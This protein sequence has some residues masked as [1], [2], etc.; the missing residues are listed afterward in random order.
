MAGPIDMGMAAVL[1]AVQ[2]ATEFLPVSSS[3]HVALGA[4]LFGVDDM[5]LAMVVL[6]HVGTLVATLA[7]FREDLVEL[8]VAT[9]RGVTRPR[10]FL[11]TDQGKLVTG[12]IVATIPTGLIGLYLEPRVESFSQVPWIVGAGLLGSA[13]AVTTTR[14]SGGEASV[15]PLWKA[16]VIG[17]AQG[18]AVM[19]GLS[20]SGT[21]I[22]VAMA[23]GMSGP[24]AFRFSF[25][26]SLPAVAGAMVL[27]LRHWDEIVA[28]GPGAMV[29]GIMALV[30]G[31]LALRWLRALVDQGRFWMFALYLVPVGLGAIAWG[32]WWR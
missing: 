20:R 16:L 24:A 14:F 6:L 11:A 12:I 2:G 3:G 7:L 9:T 18:C 19:P 27:E 28:L 5:P 10:E 26:L 30:I 1:G 23:L 17:I 32:V 4:M 31:Y 29:G 15:L 8:T 13:I 21:T 22:A 25:L